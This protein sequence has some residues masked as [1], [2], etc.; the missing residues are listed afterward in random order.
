MN[1][2]QSATRLSLLGSLAMLLAASIVGCTSPTAAP[3]DT[4]A[5]PMSKK[6]TQTATSVWETEPNND[7]ALASDVIGTSTQSGGRMGYISTASDNDYYLTASIPAGKVLT[8]NLAMPMN[9]DYDV[10]ILANDGVTVLA[11]DHRGA[12][13]SETL[14]LTNLT[15]SSQTYKLRVF[16]AN[17]SFSAISPYTLIAGIPS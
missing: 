8:V 17:G 4:S 16:S 2:E 3:D 10:Q 5:T 11:S 13:I 7:P 6:G 9:M 1:I 15:S 12:G 14:R